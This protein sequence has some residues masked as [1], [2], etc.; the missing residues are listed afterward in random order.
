MSPEASSVNPRRERMAQSRA[1]PGKGGKGRSS[2][3]VTERVGAPTAREESE[4]PVRTEREREG[5]K[6][7]RE[8]SERRGSWGGGGEGDEGGGGLMPWR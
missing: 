6:R 5:E 3:N 7:E 8:Q 2:E 1:G 4:S